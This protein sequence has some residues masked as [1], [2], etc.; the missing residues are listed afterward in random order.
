MDVFFFILV[1]NIAPIFFIICLGFILEKTFKL[2]IYS[3]SK[4]NFYVFVPALV[5]VKVYQTEI[6]FD[7]MRAITFA[8][9]FLAAMTLLSSLMAKIRG[10]KM[11][12][13]SAFKNSVMFY[14]SGNF[15]IPLITLVFAGTEY[16]AY[17]VSIQIMVLMVQ[18]L[19]TNSIGFYNAGRGQMNVKNTLI[20]TAKMP[21]LYAVLAALL[22]KIVPFNLTEFFLWPAFEYMHDGLISVALLTLGIQLSVAELELEN[23]DVYLASFS[24]LIGGPLLAYLLIQLLGIDGV[25]A[26]VLF[27]SSA[28]PSAVNTALIAV[29]FN[30]EPDFASQVVL[31]T[32]IFSAF[33]I[34]A[35]IYLSG[36]IF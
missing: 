29:E 16:A 22:L 18:N 12:R 1:N 31:T 15:G 14:N 7:L 21:S 9:I 23:M 5:L 6:Q 28:V 33:T 30:N 26:R 20:E 27:I 35:V 25:M 17:A 3:F 32:T 13:A 19:T 10:Y 34:T 24:R 11:S 36:I 2:D 8:F 4:I